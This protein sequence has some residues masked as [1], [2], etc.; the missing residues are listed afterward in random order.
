MSTLLTATNVAFGYRHRPVLRGLSLDLVQGEFVAVLGS[1]GAGKTTLLRLL[2]G[3]LKPD[4]GEVRIGNRPAHAIP[5]RER[6]TLV[7]FLP[8]RTPP[9]DG[10]AVHEVVLMGL[11][12]S[13]PVRGWESLREWRAVVETLRMVGAQDLLRRSFGCLS[14]GEQRRVLLAR[15]L[16]SKPRLLLLDE[17]LSSLDP[18]FELEFIEQLRELKRSGT[19]MIAATH[20]LGLARELA[21]RVLLLRGGQA[22]AFGPRAESLTPE[23]LDAIYGTDAFTRRAAKSRSSVRTSA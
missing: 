11:Y 22:L 3:L 8:Q 7:S 2:G 17:P 18:G 1:N 4:M 10:F 16:V 12:S 20:H 13:L 21:D 6:A 5:P 23:R 9:A 19:A 14:G 15:A